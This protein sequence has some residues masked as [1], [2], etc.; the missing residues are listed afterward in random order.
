MATTID[1][2]KKMSANGRASLKA[3]GYRSLEEA[4]KASDQRLLALPGFG[5]SSL[6]RLRLWQAGEPQPDGP[7]VDRKRE[8][9]I[10]E[11][12]GRLRVKLEPE[13]ALKSAVEEVDAVLRSLREGS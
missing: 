1:S 5:D 7:A 3:A 8:D 12:Y 9:R 6:R 4:A 2:L 10:W 11:L 13:E